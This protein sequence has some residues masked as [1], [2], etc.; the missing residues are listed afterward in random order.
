MDQRGL[1]GAVRPDDGVQLA[2]HD[3]QADIVGDGQRAIGLAQVADAQDRL[4]HGGRLL[5]RPA[6]DPRDKPGDAAARVQHDE[7]Q[8]RR[9]R[10][11]FQ[12]SENL[13][14]SLLQ[15]DQPGAPMIGPYSVPMPPSTT[16]K[17]SRPSAASVI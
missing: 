15:Q 9:R 7:N 13:A 6:R 5:V 17:I 1:A 2:R 11:S 12:C 16:M 8:D 14:S 10:P 4:S 3:V